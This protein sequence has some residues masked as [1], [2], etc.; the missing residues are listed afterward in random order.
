[1]KIRRFFAQ[2][3]AQLIK[4]L[5]R[6]VVDPQLTT[7]PLVGQLDLEPEHIGEAAFK[8]QRVRV[9]LFWTVRRLGFNPC[10]TGTLLCIPL[11][12]LFGV[13]NR[14]TFPGDLSRQADR[15]GSGY[16]GAGMA[17]RQGTPSASI[18]RT[19]SGSFSR[20]SEL[21]TWLRLLP[22]TSPRSFWV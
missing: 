8:R 21:A 16:D 19:S 12:Q 5:E 6:L 18:C 15:I 3:P 10:R 17:G 14:K 22:M 13:T 11:S 20:R 9:L 1:L 7:L 2:Q 4:L